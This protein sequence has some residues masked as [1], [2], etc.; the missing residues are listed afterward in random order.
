MEVKATIKPGQN[1]SKH[2]TRQYVDQ[3]VCIRYRYDK[4]RQKRMTTVELIVNEQDWI[5]G[6]SIP[7]IKSSH[8]ESLMVRL[9]KEKKSQIKGSVTNELH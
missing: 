2:Y 1:G 9:T 4:R 7:P 6:I 3:L 8:C 5:Q